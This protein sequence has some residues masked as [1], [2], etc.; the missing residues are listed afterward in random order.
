MGKS[1]LLKLAADER[2]IIRVTFCSLA[3][4]LRK[5]HPKATIP[6][7]KQALQNE[8]DHNSI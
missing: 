2:E 1:G 4:E 6:Q 3:D 8:L 5:N 7:I